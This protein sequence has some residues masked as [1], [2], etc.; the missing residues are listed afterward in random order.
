MLNTCLSMSVLIIFAIT[1]TGAVARS[2]GDAGPST[3]AEACYGDVS[4]DRK[5]TYYA[6]MDKADAA[7]AAGSV[8]M[9]GEAT[10]AAHQAVFRG[11]SYATAISIRCLGSEAM[12]RWFDTHLELWRQ[13]SAYGLEGRTGDFG[14]VVVIAHDRGTQGLIDVATSRPS[15]GFREAYYAITQVIERNE[16]QREFGTP[17]LPA[18]KAVA[19]ACRDALGPLDAYRHKEIAR[20]L[21]EEDKAFNQP[22]TQQEE[23]MAAQV[24]QYAQLG[25]RLSGAEIASSAEDQKTLMMLERRVDESWA[26]INKARDLEWGSRQPG[27]KTQ[28]MLRAEE[29]GDILLARANDESRSLEVRDELYDEARDYFAFC[30]CDDKRRATNSARDTIQPALEAEEERRRMAMEK[31]RAEMEQQAEAMRK[32]VDD[33]KKTD[34]EK[35]SFQDEADAMEAELGF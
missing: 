15:S 11:G 29:R 24:E 34:A 19:A 12:Q 3:F 17:L 6:E 4:A 23:R 28:A 33:M 10:L 20:A 5:A 2:H 1:A 27:D 31:K 30:D 22:M 21:A 26:Q 13:G 7:L 35:K 9:A 8:E 18:E 14:T 25:T 16:W 32:E